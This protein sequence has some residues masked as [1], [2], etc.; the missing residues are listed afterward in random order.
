MRY[1]FRLDS[2]VT[3][4]ALGRM[5]GRRF[6]IPQWTI[7]VGRLEDRPTTAGPPTVAVTP[8]EGEEGFGWILMG[9][10]ELAE[11]SGLSELD[12]ARVLAAELNVRCLVDD[13]TRNPDR[14]ILVARDGSYG[15][16]IVDEDAATEGDL[17]IDHAESPIAGEPDV[18]VIPPQVH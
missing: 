4:D 17:R 6:D 2:M 18:P 7:Y 15:P 9:D 13:G 5:L 14:W 11:A 16:V 12:L 10:H 8:P 3:A 1:Q